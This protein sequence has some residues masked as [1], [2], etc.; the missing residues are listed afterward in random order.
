MTQVF[1]PQA[2][3]RHRRNRRSRVQNRELSLLKRCALG[4]IDTL[5]WDQRHGHRLASPLIDGFVARCGTGAGGFVRSTV[6]LKT[7][8]VVLEEGR[9]LHNRAS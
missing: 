8:A 5:R 7:D 4:G 3:R 1:H 2:A 6:V 9:A